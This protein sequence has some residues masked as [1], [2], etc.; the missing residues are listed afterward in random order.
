MGQG[1]KR[2]N[3]DA[4][5]PMTRIFA[6]QNT[7]LLL[8]TN[9]LVVVHTHIQVLVIQLHNLESLHTL[10]AMPCHCYV[11]SAT[12]YASHTCCTLSCR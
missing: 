11:T 4:E 1:C 10:H 8:Q 7:G 3:D 5:E 2:G 6:K 12:R 9:P